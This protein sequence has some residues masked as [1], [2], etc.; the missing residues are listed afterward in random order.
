MKYP[1]EY[2]KYLLL[3]LAMLLLQPC[4]SFAQGKDKDKPAKYSVAYAAET[5]EALKFY[6]RNYDTF[7]KHFPGMNESMLKV[8]Y[9]VV[10]PEVSQYDAMTDF[11]EVKA[12]E[13]KYVKDGSCNYSIGYFQM[14]PIF[15]ESLE[16]EV[17][18]NAS[19]KKK[20]GKHL[21]YAKGKN[22]AT[23]R[24]ERLERMC[25]MEWQIRYLAIFIDIVKMRTAKWGLKSNKDKVRYW[26]TLY[27]AGLYLNKTRVKNRQNVKQFPRGTKEFNYSAVA[28]ELYGKLVE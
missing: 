4:F 28:V 12:L 1:L 17:F 23:V 11:F 19:L 10:A 18:N 3:C 6:K 15:V 25:E 24:A 27:N 7:K 14:K 5:R 22:S 21:A 13:A 9:C 8:V 16:K 26:A 20:Y 2:M